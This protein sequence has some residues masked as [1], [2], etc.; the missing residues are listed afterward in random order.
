[1]TASFRMLT[2]KRT[3]RFLHMI[4]ML[5]RETMMASNDEAVLHDVIGNGKS[6]AM[7]FPRDARESGLAQNISRKYGPS[8]DIMLFKPG[9]DLQA[10]ERRTLL[11]GQRKC[12]PACLHVFSLLGK[13]KKHFVCPKECEQFFEVLPANAREFRQLRQLRKP[14]GCGDVGRAHIVSRFGKNKLRIIRHS[15]DARFVANANVLRFVERRSP[16]PP[17]KH[18]RPPIEDAIIHAQHASFSGSGDDVRRIKGGGRDVGERP[19]RLSRDL[20][21]HGIARIFY[22]DELMFFGDFLKPREIRHIPEERWD[23]E[24]ARL[25]RDHAFYLIDIRQIQSWHRFDEYGNEVAF[26]DGGDGRRERERGRNHLRPFSKTERLK[27]EQV[28]R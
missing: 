27:R 16:P 4:D 22:Q 5:L 3:Y 10:R 23:H 19:R 9:D 15:A 17:G 28:C 18:A 25:F 2:H 1:M 14:E 20:G 7:L 21:A 26:Y 6:A 24:R 8:L 13:F 12:K 11:D